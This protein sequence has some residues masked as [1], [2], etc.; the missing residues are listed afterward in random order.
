MSSRLHNKFHRHN[1]HTTPIFDPRYPDAAL[2][3]IA[4]QASPFLGPFYLSGG[5]VNIDNTL[6]TIPLGNL[7]IASTVVSTDTTPLSSVTANYK[8]PVLNEN[9]TLLGYLRLSNT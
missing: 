4:S 3:P 2:D 6:S 1:H 5:L 9:G 7:Q 8:I